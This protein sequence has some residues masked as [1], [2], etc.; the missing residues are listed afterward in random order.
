MTPLTIGRYRILPIESTKKGKK[1]LS[2]VVVQ[3]DP[4][5]GERPKSPQFPSRGKCAEWLKSHIENEA[6][7]RK[8]LDSLEAENR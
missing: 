3:V 5:G 1:S 4:D 6:E 2:F 7:R 8:V